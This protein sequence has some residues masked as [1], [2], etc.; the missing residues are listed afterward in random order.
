MAIFSRS[1]PRNSGRGRLFAL[2]SNY[3]PV[4]AG[5]KNSSPRDLRSETTS[6][7]DRQRLRSKLLEPVPRTAFPLLRATKGLAHTATSVTPPRRSSPSD[8]RQGRDTG[9]RGALIWRVARIAIRRLHNRE[10]WVRASN[11]RGR[12]PEN[13]LHD[14]LGGA[15][16]RC[17]GNERGVHFRRST[18]CCSDGPH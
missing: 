17:S 1:Q 13:R 16:E 9:P 5:F 4:A 12:V 14:V 2:A 15:D 10:N 7:V 11:S 8:W 6:G 3:E 18:P